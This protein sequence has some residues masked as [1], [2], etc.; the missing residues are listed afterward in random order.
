MNLA[1]TADERSVA[2]ENGETAYFPYSE[3]ISFSYQLT[4][5]NSDSE[6]NILNGDWGKDE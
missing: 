5:T 2:L 3:G 1:V 4:M 6:T